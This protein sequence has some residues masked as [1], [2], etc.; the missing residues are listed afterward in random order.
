MGKTV[1]VYQ[2]LSPW[3]LLHPGSTQWANYFPF[4]STTGRW[5]FSGRVALHL[6]LPTLHLPAG[7]TIL[8]PNYFQGVEIDTLLHNGHKLCFY[9]V[10]RNLNVDLEDVRS[11]IIPSVSALHVIHYFGWPQAM[12][13]IT[14]F[15]Q[16]HGLKLIEDCALALF[17]RDQKSWLGS[18]GDLALFSVYKTL[19]L[20]HGGFLV[21]KGSTAK[22]RLRPAPMSTTL[23]QT[24]DLF[25]QHMRATGWIHTEH[26]LRTALGRLK[27]FGSGTS[28][29]DIRSGGAHW[30]SRLVEYGAAAWVQSL[31]RIVSP[32]DVITR[33]RRNFEHLAGKLGGRAQSPLP[34]LPPEACP[35][36]FPVMVGNKL[37]VINRLASRGVGSVNLW[38]EPH[39]ACPQ[40]MTAEVAHIRE[41][42][43]ELPIHQS[44]SL[45]D[46]DRIADTFIEITEL[47]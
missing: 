13:R 5:T 27:S 24:T 46:I 33:R 47:E 28:A 9:R 36:F 34:P 8:V 43:L 25:Q 32:A 37:A 4:S 6:G 26:A 38:W 16:E 41:H 31:M 2:T 18:Y 20:P 40:D 11:R 45:D 1:P 30:D 10:D 44:L 12:E 14:R 7:S 39:P 22:G 35:L 29:E 3:D 21:T 19:P 23:A 15:C 17:S 42:L